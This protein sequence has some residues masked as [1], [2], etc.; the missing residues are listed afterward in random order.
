MLDAATR[1]AF[2]GSTWLAP[3]EPAEEDFA[4]HRAGDDSAADLEWVGFTALP[5][6]GGLGL[7][8]PVVELAVI[9]HEDGGAVVGGG[10]R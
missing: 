10:F 4:A 9:R 3:S 2:C 8:V 7:V 6:S 5:I 1:C